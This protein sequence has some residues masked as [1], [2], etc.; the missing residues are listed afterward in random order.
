VPKHSVP[1]LGPSRRRTPDSVRYPVPGRTCRSDRVIVGLLHQPSSLLFVRCAEA[2]YPRVRGKI[3]AL[4]SDAHLI[5]SPLPP[6]RSRLFLQRSPLRAH[7]QPFHSAPVPSAPS[8]S[9]SQSSLVRKEKAS[10]G[11]SLELSGRVCS[12]WVDEGSANRTASRA[13]PRPPPASHS[14]HMPSVLQPRARGTTV[15]GCSNGK[16]PDQT[17]VPSVL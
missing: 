13:A 5:L 2:T 16:S 15:R 4:S 10:R 17:P 11:A 9:A 14:V 7:L 12:S 8:R 1:R 6:Q 3:Q